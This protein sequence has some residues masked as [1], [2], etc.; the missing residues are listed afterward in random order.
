MRTQ[1]LL[2][3]SIALSGC[4]IFTNPPPPAPPAPPAPKSAEPHG[5]T[6]GEEARLL[7]MED[8]RLFDPAVVSEWLANP[9]AL[10]RTRM[11]LALGRI[12]PSTF[13][14]A[15]RNGEQDAGER[16]AGVEQLVAL[17][18]DS[19]RNVR[20]SAAFSLGEIGDPTS[21]DALLAL[22]Q[23]REDAGVAAEAIEAL[24]KL[25][26]H[27]PFAQYAELAGAAQR[28][29][30]RA[31][32]I[33]FLFRFNSDEASALAAASLDSPSPNIRQ[34]ATYALARR[35]YAPA[36]ERLELLAGD[37]AYAT[38]ANVAAA[39]G[40]IAA[41]ESLPLLLDALLDAHPWVRT[42][43]VIAIG[44]IAAKEPTAIVRT[45][46]TRFADD[47]LR[48]IDLSNDPDPGTRASSIDILGWYA[49]KSEQARKRLVEIAANG[50][51]WDRELAA[52]AIARHLPAELAPTLDTAS[53]WARVRILENTKDE[54][55]GIA[56]R[57]R[58]AA[59]ADPLVRSNALANIPDAHVD[60]ELG[61]IRPALD[62]DDVIVRANAIDRYTLAK[63]A[64]DALLLAAEQRAQKDS[65]NDARIAAINGIAA[66]DTPQR[67]AF[68]R[69]LVADRDPV[70]RRIAV[71]ALV[72]KLKKPRLQYTP[73]PSGRSADEYAQIVT[74]ARQSHHA[75]IKLTRGP[76]E[77]ALVAQDAP[78][79]AWNFA[80]L[81]RRGYY[82]DS[83]LMRVVPNFVG[84]GGDPRND[85]NGGPGYA[86]RDEINLQKYTR[87]AV[88]MALSGPDTG[89]SQFF[90]THSP[91]PHLDGGYTIFGRVVA[92]MNEVVDQ[93]ER[94]DR[95]ETITID[96]G[97]S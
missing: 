50:S 31:R 94:G 93:T 23:D 19:D 5:F 2:F 66:I 53:P 91:Q 90:I 76:I 30:V 3:L 82:N 60:A 39:L 71:D 52:G 47:A 13:V 12:G 79:T 69:G 73:L 17:V 88:G 86:I 92:G 95:V 42:N 6:I 54:E 33:Q 9:N 87:G 77:I 49:E 10:H 80:Q 37:A 70:V 43:A 1:A 55:R 78:I 45:P 38:R 65:Q 29:G 58:F 61:I 15:N 97:R 16:Q 36:R 96:G 25:A 72:D 26:A 18:H 22:A 59:D 68:L 32:A 34:V 27:V 56:L 89:G 4:A 84:Q 62:A 28:E 64:D 41:K 81:A 7:A 11:A 51:R 40:R 20:E 21:V 35:A 83:S 44:K 74:W 8:Q 67:E 24:S 46:V 85:M 63:G 14:D 48:I 75:T 57:A